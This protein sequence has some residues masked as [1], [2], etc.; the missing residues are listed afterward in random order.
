MTAQDE[1]IYQAIAFAVSYCQ[2][3]GTWVTADGIYSEYIN[4]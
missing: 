2:R 4:N 1:E 3:H